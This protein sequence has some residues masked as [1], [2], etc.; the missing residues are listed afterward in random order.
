VSDFCCLESCFLCF[1]G[2]S[3]RLDRI[4]TGAGTSCGEE[5]VLHPF[6]GDVDILG[7]IV[8]VVP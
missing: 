3:A 4:P 7:V 2:F 5:D 1:F 8:C 6:L